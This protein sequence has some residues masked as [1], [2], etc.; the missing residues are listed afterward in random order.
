MTDFQFRAPADIRFVAKDAF[1]DAMACLGSTVCLIASHDGR[2][3]HGRIVT[4]AISLSVEPP[5]VLA[6]IDIASPLA[7]IILRAQSFSY[8]VLSERQWAI[9]EAFVSRGEPEKRFEHGAWGSWTSGQPRL[10]GTVA[11]MDC[12]LIGEMK[13]A[14]HLLVIGGVVDID[15]CADAGPLIWH[16]RKFARIEGAGGSSSVETDLP[17][18]G[19]WARA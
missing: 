4:A 18:T 17:S 9:A 12:R 15:T 6:A 19:P 10:G 13:T 2:Q 5:A 1:R 16:R 14:S 3:R 7:E 8:S 11:S